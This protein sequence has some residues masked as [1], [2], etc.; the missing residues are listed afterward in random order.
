MHTRAERV[1]LRSRYRLKANQVLE[2]RDSSNSG[3]TLLAVQ[4]VSDQCQHPSPLRSKLSPSSSSFD[5]T[6]R[7]APHTP[8]ITKSPASSS[9]I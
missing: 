5:P 7:T 4:F 6:R 2:P 3:L 1:R 9:P 8:V